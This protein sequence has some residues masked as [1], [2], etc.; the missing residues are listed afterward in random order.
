MTWRPRPLAFTGK[1]NT[2]KQGIGA[3]GSGRSYGTSDAVPAA[4]ES[5]TRSWCCYASL[6]LVS[7]VVVLLLILGVVI[8][9]ALLLI[10]QSEFSPAVVLYHALRRLVPAAVK[11]GVAA[12]LVLSPSIV[13]LLALDLQ[14]F[15]KD[16]PAMKSRAL[17]L[18]AAAT[19]VLSSHHIDVA[20]VERHLLEWIKAK[21]EYIVTE[22]VAIGI[23]V[24]SA[25]VLTFLCLLFIL[26]TRQADTK[27][28]AMGV[29][30]VW[31]EIDEQVRRYMVLQ[32]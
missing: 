22:S 28:P 11:K 9:V 6:R 21:S 18:T 5:S 19:S 30:S 3:A 26:I 4:E 8:C 7:V 23:N 13:T 25:L 14:I 15:V 10:N 24:T 20:D 16:W 12:I 32:T 31:A 27:P 2:A 29:K 1:R 17:S